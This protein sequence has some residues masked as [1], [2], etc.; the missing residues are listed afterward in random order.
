[1]KKRI[2]S[3]I[4]ALCMLISLFPVTAL[5]TYSDIDGH[6]GEEAIEKW[7]EY[8]IVEGDGKNFN[9]D[10]LM[11][12]GA[13]AAV[14]ARLLGLSDKAD[15]S[16]YTDVNADAWYADAIAM[17][18][19]AGIMSG[20]A[21]NLMDPNGPLTRE[22]FFV[23]YARALGIEEEETMDKSF[24]DA[25]EISDWAQGSINALVNKGF[26]DGISDGTLAP[27]V[28]INRA[29][30]ISLLDKSIA[31][32]VNEDN[33]EV[34]VEG[35]GIVLVVADNVTIKGEGD[36]TLVAATD[37]E[38]EFKDFEGEVAINIVSDG[39][40]IKNAPAD[41]ELNVK[42]GVE[43]AK[44][45]DKVVDETTNEVPSAG[46]S[47]GGG[48]TGGGSTGGGSTG[49]GS[50]GGGSTGGDSTGG[51]STGGDSTEG[52][53]PAEDIPVQAVTDITSMQQTGMTI[54]IGV[55]LPSDMTGIDYFTLAFYDS[56]YEE[57]SKMEGIT[58]SKDHPYFYVD[59]DKFDTRYMYDTVEI[60]S[61]PL[62]GY[63]E[64]VYTEAVSTNI[65][66]TNLNITPYFEA[67]TADGNTNR[68][69][70]EFDK[71]A[72]NAFMHTA[73]WENE[74]EEYPIDNENAY[75]DVEADGM[76]VY[77][78]TIAAEIAAINAETALVGLRGWNVSQLDEVNGKWTI[79]ANIY[80]AVENKAVEIK[81]VTPENPQPSQGNLHFVANSY[82][83]LP[84]LVWDAVDGAAEYKVIFTPH[85]ESDAG[86]DP[87]EVTTDSNSLI[88]YTLRV[89]GYVGIKVIA[90]DENGNAIETFEDEDM[91]FG[92][93]TE[94]DTN[95]DSTPKAEF[96]GPDDNGNYNVA[97][98]GFKA[99]SVIWLELF[100]A[101]DNRE[102]EIMG[103]T[104]G[105]GKANLTVG[106]PVANIAG[107]IADGKYS[108]T[109]IETLEMQDTSARIK[110][111]WNITKAQVPA[112][113]EVQSKM[114]FETDSKGIA[115]LKW[116]A[117]EGVNDYKVIITDVNNNTVEKT[118][119]HNTMILHNLP[120]NGY[121]GIK[122]IAR[123]SAQT[124]LAVYEDADMFFAINTKDAEGN[125]PTVTFN[126]NNDGTYHVEVIGYKAESAFWLELFDKNGNRKFD[127]IEYTDEEGNAYF[128]IQSSNAAECIAEGK[129]SFTGIATTELRDNNAVLQL[130]WVIEMTQCTP[131][132]ELVKVNAAT[133]IN[134][135]E[136]HG[137]VQVHVDLPEDKTG[138]EYFTFTFYDST[139]PEASRMEGITCNE[140]DPTFYVTEDKFDSRFNYDRA[141]VTS[142]PLEGYEKAVYTENV[143]INIEQITVG[144][145]PVFVMPTDGN[146]NRVEI[147]LD[148]A[149]TPGMLMHIAVWENAEAEQP[150][151]NTNIGEYN[152]VSSDG[153]SVSRSVSEAESTA[154]QAG[155]ALIS[156]DKYSFSAE[157]KNDV[158]TLDFT[159]I[160]S[161]KTAVQIQQPQQPSATIENVRFESE[162][163][164]VYLKWDAVANAKKYEVKFT[165]DGGTTWGNKTNA[166]NNFFRICLEDAAVY[167]GVKISAIDVD[168]N[169]IT[170]AEDMSLSLTVTQGAALEWGNRVISL[171]KVKTNEYDM[172]I[173]GMP[174]NAHYDVKFVTELG[175]NAYSKF[176]SDADA[177]GVAVS[178]ISS[179]KLDNCV[180][181]GYYS[182]IEHDAATVTNNGKTVSVTVRMT[183]EKKCTEE[184]ESGIVT[185]VY[186]SNCEGVYLMW[187]I[188]EDD[189][190]Q[191]NYDVYLSENGG[192]DWTFVGS[193]SDESLDVMTPY[194]R[195]EA[196]ATVTYNAVKIVA[197][198]GGTE[199]ETFVDKEI[200][201][202][203]TP[204]SSIQNPTVSFKHIEA[205]NY[206]TSTIKMNVERNT[207]YRAFFYDTA[208][209]PVSAEYI[210]FN[211]YGS[212]QE[213]TF[214][215]AN[216]ST[217]NA[218]K[219]GYYEIAA[220]K[221]V[222]VDGTGK[223]ASY[224]IGKT[225]A[226]VA[227]TPSDS[228]DVEIK[229]IEGTGDVQVN[230]EMPA[231]YDSVKLVITEKGY[232]TEIFSEELN[233]N[234]IPDITKYLPHTEYNANYSINLVGIKSGVKQDVF[235]TIPVAVTVYDIQPYSYEMVF[236]S[237]GKNH[238]AKL[239]PRNGAL[240]LLASW[241][242]G[243][244][245][246]IPAPTEEM[247]FA[248]A[249][250]VVLTDGDYIS[251]SAILSASVE[252]G[253]VNVKM[254]P[255]AKTEY[256]EIGQAWLN[257][258]VGDISFNWSAHPTTN[259]YAVGKSY[260]TLT[261]K[262]ENSTV[263]SIL[264]F[265]VGMK[266]NTAM[267][268]YV[269]SRYPTGEW[270]RLNNAV[271]IK[272]GSS[273]DMGIIGQA[274]GSY[275]FE[276][277]VPANTGRMFVFEM[278]DPD[279]NRISGYNGYYGDSSTTDRRIY[280]MP[281]ET[282]N[283]APYEGCTF[284]VYQYDWTI[285]ANLNTVEVTR[286]Y[287][288]NIPFVAYEGFVAETEVRT[289][290]EFTAAINKSGTVKLMSNITLAYE[291]GKLAVYANRGGAVT[292]DLN[293]YN[294]HL[295]QNINF[296]IENGKQM[297]IKN[298]TIT[299]YVAGEYED[300]EGVNS[301]SKI[302]VGT[303]SYFELLDGTYVNVEATTSESIVIK[304]AV[305]NGYVVASAPQVTI[306]N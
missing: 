152:N 149:L 64:A 229:V 30:V 46:G 202:K 8:G 59:R 289:E 206:Y 34:T 250:D 220:I 13:A 98:S 9:P 298:G 10:G 14:F 235:A 141:E 43:D 135:I 54:K 240:K 184:E 44:V 116:D 295:D 260:E 259:E 153:L 189:Y 45:N 230:F 179:S 239:Q 92:I 224:K 127:T 143:S 70:V 286:S 102:F 21:G 305:I 244:N 197:S 66:R 137:S 252:D 211:N 31:A 148:N 285:G 255:A 203:L 195:S 88:L 221:D 256:E 140:G 73:V 163:G 176:G 253:M 160:K 53:D 186:F 177:N 209:N 225:P 281:N 107:C 238:T 226:L 85:P 200:S 191:Y 210:Y 178:T 264:E 49:G 272:E 28:D 38:V 130:E 151:M 101:N 24:N 257:A 302:M 110:F 233:G 37:G 76:S 268:V 25:G 11:T 91:F 201:L 147:T 74:N 58:C 89:N 103:E 15:I 251:I 19:E 108:I 172:E 216:Q 48:S 265:I 294:L 301:S 222:S 248:L 154:I 120:A 245:V 115:I 249:S 3:G 263:L 283:V 77:R 306:E 27:D 158:W 136:K 125:A 145:S 254:T 171:T 297:T 280:V 97:V 182:I 217:V 121:R 22:Q 187:N 79:T 16:K 299:G 232:S 270:A 199:V 139:N 86:T 204:L 275:K 78:S 144:I 161:A 188:A 60:V 284:N 2:T 111:W 214:Y 90:V 57:A 157:K 300:V 52:N 105:N 17:C 122:I 134:N 32:Y 87:V 94:P 133:G 194:L 35:N 274:D 119:G 29:S 42:E 218:I 126:K 12:R 4:L 205:G 223:S 23:M 242:D 190:N 293:G 262:V 303:G 84:D 75:S 99:N 100:D 83:G 237:D 246:A 212:G 167:N 117:V 6:W 7:S 41:A 166:G 228:L 82:T 128:D 69:T 63:K 156:I 296:N 138:I 113:E 50:T 47:T 39:A 219:N 169:V 165:T 55:E 142:L 208:K 185:G 170:T 180:E 146:P 20:V 40:E 124:E 80:E 93:D 193:V 247:N 164:C 68:L 175:S 291:P 67:V 168:G 26:I 96:S 261:T 162:N 277:N 150:I 181:N 236:G 258:G 173:T 61:K 304:D 282:I 129:Y 81:T 5:A 131:E 207:E 109:R 266:E 104:D 267:D 123:D 36:I 155:N 51:G 198:C 290:A 1:M 276:T 241:N 106:H 278:V 118:A 215:F 192:T 234:V 213:N 273:V 72:M 33:A 287:K 183:E 65:T 279:G 288:K 231:E 243:M 271:T 196:Y 269:E 18:V 62:E 132:V 71:A 292:L 114:R 159:N 174:A 95:T 227:C 112:E 56:V